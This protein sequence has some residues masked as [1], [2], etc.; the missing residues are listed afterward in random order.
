[1]SIIIYNA[2]TNC[3]RIIISFWNKE[4]YSQN[5]NKFECLSLLIKCAIIAIV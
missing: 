1:M 5:S 3:K 2:H 4:S